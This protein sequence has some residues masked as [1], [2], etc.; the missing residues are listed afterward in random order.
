VRLHFLEEGDFPPTSLG[1]GKIQE[2]QVNNLN[3]AAQPQRA[4]DTF[5]DLR[6]RTSKNLWTR[7]R[8]DCVQESSRVVDGAMR[9]ANTYLP[10]QDVFL[11]KLLGDRFLNFS[12]D[13]NLVVERG[14]SAPPF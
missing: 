10:R 4:V 9:D 12:C 1:F 14:A 7:V 5:P 2:R 11:F 13:S 8:F 3:T 6:L